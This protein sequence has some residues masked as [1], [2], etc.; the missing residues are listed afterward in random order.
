MLH[1]TSSIMHQN[2]GAC[3]I[4]GIGDV[5]L[6]KSTGCRMVLRDVCHNLE[7]RLNLISTGRLNDEGY[8]GSFKNDTLKF[9]KEN[10]IVARA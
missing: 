6:L 9:S 4:V 5:C 10:L 7:I 2:D 1:N 3:E 8:I